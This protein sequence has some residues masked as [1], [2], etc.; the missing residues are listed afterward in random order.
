MKRSTKKVMYQVCFLMVGMVVLLVS[1]SLYT[2]KEELKKSN[3]VVDH[4]F[5][6]N[7]EQH[8]PLVT[9]YAK[10]YA[11]EEHV[12]VLLAM[13]MQES[14][15]R[16]DDP[17][18]SSESLC[19]QIGCIDDPE[20]SIKQGVDYFSRALERTDGDVEL[21]VQSYNFG[22]GFVNY[23]EEQETTYSQDVVI[24]FSQKMYDTAEDQSIYTCLREEAKQYDAC[25]GDIYYARDV[26]A[27]KNKFAK[28]D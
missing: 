24:A 23:V 7:V 9:K 17:M 1:I 2:N 21:A 13:M 28:K 26:M 14:G 10:L 11:V 18:Q 6:K 20:A 12:D 19:G 8:R 5:T 22:I 27:Y 4:V 15:G 16:G 3:P 25:Y